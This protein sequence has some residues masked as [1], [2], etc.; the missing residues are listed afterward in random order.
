[1]H[2]H[3][4]ASLSRILLNDRFEYACLDELCL[5]TH[6]FEPFNAYVFALGMY[7]NMMIDIC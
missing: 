1:M 2:S 4:Y 5:I 3:E 7:D 6:L